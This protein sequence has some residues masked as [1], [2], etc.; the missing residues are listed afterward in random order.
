M[1]QSLFCSEFFHKGEAR[2][3]V[4][5]ELFQP[6]T[7]K[8]LRSLHL[9]WC[10]VNVFLHVILLLLIP[11]DFDGH[12]TRLITPQQKDD[13]LGTFSDIRT[14]ACCMTLCAA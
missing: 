14:Q 2:A 9:D 8:V 12:K 5:L 6:W 7:L 13:S 4:V 11:A 3:I 10:A 1:C